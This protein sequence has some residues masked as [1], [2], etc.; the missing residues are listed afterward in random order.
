MCWAAPFGTVTISAIA[1]PAAVALDKPRGVL[2]DVVSHRC[3]LC[4]IVN[5]KK[6]SWFGAYSTLPRETTMH[7][8]K[9]S[10]DDG[11]RAIIAG[12]TLEDFERLNRLDHANNLRYIIR[13]TKWLNDHGVEL[14]QRY[15]QD[16]L[17]GAGMTVEQYLQ[18][19]TVH[20]DCCHI[21]LKK[22][23]DSRRS[24]DARQ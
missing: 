2:S 7:K 16:F 13:G 10:R 12:F 19:L 18:A 1:S 20:I 21:L 4:R 11:R 3:C 9:V 23:E 22:I 24:H 6:S 17:D 5:G 8:R 14:L 15:P